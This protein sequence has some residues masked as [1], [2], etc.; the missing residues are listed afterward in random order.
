VVNF[1]GLDDQY[2]SFE[3][4][5]FVVIPIPYDL[6][7]SYQS[8][9]RRG[10]AAILD[11]SFQLE[12][13]DEELHREPYRSGIHTMLPIE[14]DVRGPE[15]MT[16][17]IH[18]VV[19]NVAAAGK[20]PVVLGGEHTV[21]IGTVRAIKEH[22]PDIMVLHLDAH[23]DMRDTYQGSP[24][25]HACVGRRIWELCPLVEVGVRSMSGECAAFIEHKKVK[26]FPADFKD[27]HANWEKIISENF[28]KDVYI[29]VDLD[30]LDPSIMPATGT[31][32][33]GGLYWK[34]IVRLIREVSQRCTVR[35]FD[36]VELAPIPGMIAPDYTAARLAYKMMGYI[37][38]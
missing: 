21:T 9:A 6:T 35:G 18:G 1:C 24:Y 26:V 36:I 8:G 33:P 37:A 23:A 4:S 38:R 16:R 17:K 3:K 7:V 34:D 14:P 32:E 10:A 19:Q 20:I 28:A 15:E 11:A 31:P 13:Y 29:T 2:A 22:Y 25:S 30:V 5:H 27:E 12:L